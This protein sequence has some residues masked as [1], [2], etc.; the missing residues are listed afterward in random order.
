ML[1]QKY[2]VNE[3]DIIAHPP[4]PHVAHAHRAD[5]TA[6]PS[7]DEPFGRSKT[8]ECPH[9]NHEIKLTEALAELHS[10]L[11]VPS[12]PNSFGYLANY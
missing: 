11:V 10:V 5:A 1:L 4:P 9:A 7:H 3:P 6:Y 2:V 12:A 8:H